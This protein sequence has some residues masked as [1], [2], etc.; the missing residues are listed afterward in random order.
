MTRRSGCTA[1]ARVINTG[2]QPIL[3]LSAGFCVITGV[4]VAYRFLYNELEAD[5]FQYR[6]L[7]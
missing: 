3:N 7:I 4:I 5:I 2:T 6:I 1:N